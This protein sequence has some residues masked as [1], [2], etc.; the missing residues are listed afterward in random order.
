MGTARLES[1]VLQDTLYCS[2]FARGRELGLEDDTEGT[3]PHNLALGILHVSS[4][5]GYAVLNPFADNLCH[6]DIS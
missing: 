3:V 5:P 4:L 2:V 6:I 1:L